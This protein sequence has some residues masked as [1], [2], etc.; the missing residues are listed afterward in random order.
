[1]IPLFFILAAAATPPLAEVPEDVALRVRAGL[2]RLSPAFELTTVTRERSGYFVYHL[3]ARKPAAANRQL[4]E[5]ARRALESM[6]V[7]VENSGDSQGAKLDLDRTLEVLGGLD[8]QVRGLGDEAW[9]SSVAGEASSTSLYVRHLQYR[10]T[11]NAPTAALARGFARA[12]VELIGGTTTASTPAKD[13]PERVRDAVERGERALHYVATS[14]ASRGRAV[15]IQWQLRRAPYQITKP[16]DEFS[17]G[18]TVFVGVFESRGPE[19]ATKL[20]A[21]RPRGFEPDDL[22]GVV[23]AGWVRSED[24]DGPT[25]V[26]LRKGRYV[27]NVQ[28]PTAATARRCAIAAAGA[29]GP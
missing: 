1:M 9:S 23:D 19:E 12:A 5:G 24:G 16:A 7:R 14:I 17:D 26:L 18:E 6:Y 29:V 27:S 3:N 25:I 13:M 21:D 2:E 22:G 28:A 8:C 15:S 11:V 4:T 20:L 10:V